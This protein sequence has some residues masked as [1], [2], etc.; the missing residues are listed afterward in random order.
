MSTNLQRP[1]ENGSV[2]MPAATAVM[3]THLSGRSPNRSSLVGSL[4][5]RSSTA[6]MAHLDSA[7]DMPAEA[8][9]TTIMIPARFP[10]MPVL[11][12]K[13]KTT[14]PMT[15]SPTAA[16]ARTKGARRS[17]RPCLR[18]RLSTSRRA[19]ARPVTRTWSLPSTCAH[20]WTP[21]QKSTD[22]LV[23]FADSGGCVTISIVLI[24][25][26]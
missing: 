21:I 18:P 8:S 10:T 24:E 5:S 2:P 11:R 26:M 7:A 20:A 15:Q 16:P 17:H 9:N 1:V 14:L 23:F 3:P 12:T 6:G 13:L 22:T 19:V 4:G 25:W